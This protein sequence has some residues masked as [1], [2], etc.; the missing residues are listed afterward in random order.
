[1]TKKWAQTKDHGS[2]GQRIQ[3]KKDLFI[4]RLRLGISRRLAQAGFVLRT[5]AKEKS[6]LRNI[7]RHV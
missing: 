2:K 6:K 7:D 3:P 4:G 5:Q 1:M